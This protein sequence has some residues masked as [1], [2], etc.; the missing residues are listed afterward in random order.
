VLTAPEGGGTEEVSELFCLV[1]SL[2]DPEEYPALDLACCLPGPMGL[3]A[4][5]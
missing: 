1:T 2:L 4:R 5:S 3:R